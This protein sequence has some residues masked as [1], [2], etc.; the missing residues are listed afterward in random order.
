MYR[1]PHIVV[2]LSTALATTA[3]AASASAASFSGVVVHKDARAHSFVVALRGGALRAIHAR[4]SPALGRDVTVQ[5]RLLRNGTWA[6]QHV[7]I[8]RAVGRVHLRGTVTFVNSRRGILVVSAR[9]VSLLVREHRAMT[10]RLHAATD[11]QF[12]DGEVVTVDGTL[13]GNSVDASGVQQSGQNTNGIDLEAIV[14]G[15]DPTARTL[16]VSAD[17]SEQSGATLTVDVPAAFDITLFSTGE[18]VELIVSPNGDGTYTLEQASNDNG[19]SSANS[20]SE[21]QGDNGGDQHASAE[22]TC[23]A[24]QSDPNFAATHN[25]ESFVQ[26][27]E[28]DPNNPNDAFGKCVDAMAHGTT[29]SPSPELA[30]HM[31]ASDPNFASSHNGET[32]AQFYNSQDPSNLN[33]AF[34]N[35]IDAK[36]QQ[37]DQQGSGG[38]DS[39]GSSSSGSGSSG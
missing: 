31:E 18:S 7:R 12:A 30:C 36:A 6:L 38:Q 16:T 9:G 39:S 27:W 15:I 22:Q 17:D 25:G 4:R 10:G 23:A 11:S 2:A 3:L 20:A 32:F 24:E 33:D 35:C 26:F 5:A 21:D 13:E 1:R 8:G 29:A 28:T 37:Q 34:G 14:Q 19:A